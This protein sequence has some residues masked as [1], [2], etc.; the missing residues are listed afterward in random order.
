LRI[1]GSPWGG[2]F[3][4]PNEI[5]KLCTPLTL[6]RGFNFN[7]LKAII[8]VN[9]NSSGQVSSK[10]TYFKTPTIATRQKV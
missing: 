8:A 6:K 7:D 9:R 5:V 2:L 1:N 3:F 10:K 4:C